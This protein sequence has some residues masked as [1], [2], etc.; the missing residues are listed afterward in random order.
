MNLPKTLDIE[1]LDKPTKMPFPQLIK[2]TAGRQDDDLVVFGLKPLINKVVS[3]MIFPFHWVSACKLFSLQA[4][5]DINFVINLYRLLKTH[6]IPR[7]VYS[8]C[9]L[10]RCQDGDMQPYKHKNFICRFHD[11]VFNL[12]SL[13]LNSKL[14]IVV[15]LLNRDFYKTKL[16]NIFRDTLL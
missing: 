7:W 12:N 15:L 11:N 2:H 6:C 10:F 3:L 8:F 4:G 1:K 9:Q 5:I 13:R 14:I 16:W